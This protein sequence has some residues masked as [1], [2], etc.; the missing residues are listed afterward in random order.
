M[1]ELGINLICANSPQAKGRVEKAN[2]TLQDRLVKEMRLNNINNINAA[3]DFLPLFVFDYNKRFAIEAT[4]QIDA[5]RKTLPEP[6][7]LD[8]LMSKQAVRKLSK[9]LEL[10]YQNVLYQL[11]IKTPSYSMRGAHITVCDQGGKV[12]LLYK[13][14][15]IDYKTLNKKHRETPVST[16]KEIESFKLGLQSN[17]PSKNHPWNKYLS[18]FVMKGAVAKGDISTLG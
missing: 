15:A 14:R 7:I 18:L 8:L 9:N 3:N 12:T 1:R 17:S 4:S 13:G 16:A 5:H 2:R 11:Q 10:S 6:E